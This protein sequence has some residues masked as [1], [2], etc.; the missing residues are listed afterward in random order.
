MFM[1]A[2]YL[3]FFAVFYKAKVLACGKA[4]HGQ[5][6][7]CRTRSHCV[8]QS[9]CEAVPYFRGDEHL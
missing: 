3:D 5:E 9:H 8:A 7:T 1:L 4:S 6:N 2:T